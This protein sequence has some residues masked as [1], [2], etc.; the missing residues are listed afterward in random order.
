MVGRKEKKRLLRSNAQRERKILQRAQLFARRNSFNPGILSSQPPKT[1]VQLVSKQCPLKG[2][3]SSGHLNGLDQRHI[4]ISACPLYHNAPPQ[5]WRQMRE[6]EEGIAPS[7]PTASSADTIT[8]SPAVN[9]ASHLYTLREPNLEKLTSS[10]F[11]YQFR[12]AQQKLVSEVEREV[13]EHLIF[14]ARLR[15]LEQKANPSTNLISDTLATQADASKEMPVNNIRAIVFGEWEMQTWYASMYPPEVACLPL[16]YICEFCLTYMRYNIAYRRHRLRC[17]RKFPPGNEIYRRGTLSFFEVDGEKQ[18]E[19]CRN[20]CLL[21]KL[22]L[23][24]KTVHELDRV[25]AF[26]FYILTEA[27]EAGC[28]IIGYFS[29]HKPEEQDCPPSATYNNLSCLLIMPHYQRKGYGRMLVEF[30]YLLSRLEGRVGSPERP[31]SDHGLL[32]YQNYWRWVV[33]SYLAAYELREINIRSVS[34]SLGVDVRDIVSTLLDLGLLKYIRTEYYIVNDKSV[35]RRIL[36]EM[37]PPDESRRIDRNLLHWRP[38]K[39]SQS[40]NTEAPV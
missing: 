24:Q 38:P 34:E 30:S 19:Y 2:C 9:R 6:R 36:S 22:Y 16:I 5:Y 35:F 29:K 32:L 39:A 12:R 18:K 33:V 4:T 37:R 8:M 7:E 11:L 21:A 25:P 10:V 14:S 23:K 17:K 15:Q 20:I 1:P 40:A 27:D 13:Q 31:L 26:L 3:D 28:H